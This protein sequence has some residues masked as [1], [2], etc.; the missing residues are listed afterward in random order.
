MTRAAVEGDPR[1]GVSD[2][3][4]DREGPSFTVDTL[5]HFR[6]ELPEAEILFLMGVDQ[7]K[8]IHLWREFE[9]LPTLSRLV[10]MARDGLPPEELRSAVSVE[11]HP[12]S[13]TRVDVSSTGIRARVRE[14]RPIRYLV[15]RSV[16]DIIEK[17][18]LYQGDRAVDRTEVS[19]AGWS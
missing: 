1:L 11:F 14:G 12:I 13:V 7:L 15:P 3:E 17:N 19:A 10:A 4:L 18:Q 6:R 16:R 5:R 2:V 9:S 8:E